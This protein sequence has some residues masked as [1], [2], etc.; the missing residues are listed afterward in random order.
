MRYRGVRRRPWGRYAA[1]IRDPLSKERRWLGTFDTAEQAACAYDIAARAMRGMRARTNFVYPSSPPSSPSPLPPPHPAAGGFHG[2]D[3]RPP[4]SLWPFPWA[5]EA[6]AP[7]Q[8]HAGSV[9]SSPSS[10]SFN[11]LLLRNLISSCAASSSS[12]SASSSTFRARPAFPREQ[13]RVASSPAVPAAG[14]I[15]C[16]G[17]ASVAIPNIGASA[18][19]QELPVYTEP[20]LAP[21]ADAGFSE[22]FPS[23]PDHSGL[24]EEIVQ[25]FFPQWNSSSSSTA[26]SASSTLQSASGCYGAGMEGQ[27]EKAMEVDALEQENMKHA[28]MDDLSRYLDYEAHPPPVPS[29]Q[30]QHHVQPHH[31]QPQPGNSPYQQYCYGGGHPAP[32]ETHEGD[33]CENFPTLPQGMLE[34]IIQYPEFFEILSAKLQQRA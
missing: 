27:R 2:S 20:P 32:P 23:E 26:C 6:A 12:P 14:S 11:T 18:P 15:G 9:S 34:D 24:L 21:A 29:E 5:P 33:V 3:G 30:K 10:S 25:R 22:F 7:L 13:S 31:Q 28:E 17:G 1:E 16:C 4:P 8:H 19:F